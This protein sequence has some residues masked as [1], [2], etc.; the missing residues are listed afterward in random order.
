MAPDNTNNYC[1]CWNIEPEYTI[2]LNEQGPPGDN[3]LQGEE[4]FSPTITV[5]TNTSTEYKLAITNKDGSF[6]TPNLYGSKE[7]AEQDLSNVVQPMNIETVYPNPSDENDRLI[8]GLT[9][10]YLDINWTPNPSGSGGNWSASATARIQTKHQKYD[11]KQQIWFD[12]GTQTISLIPKYSPATEETLGLVKVDG[13][14]ITVT[15]DG[16]ISAVESGSSYVL[17]PATN[18]T[19]GG[20]K[21]GEG[22]SI[23]DDGTLSV[24]GGETGTTDYNDLTNKP[25]I[26]S[27]TLSGNVSPATLGFPTLAGDN[28]FSGYN[29]FAHLAM[30][31]IAPV[32]APYQSYI[33]FANQESFADGTA[34]YL[35]T[36]DYQSAIVLRS[37]Y[38]DVYIGR[39]TEGSTTGYTNYK[40]IDSGNI[41][42]YINQS[43]SIT[44]L[45]SQIEA[46]TARVAA[47]EA[48]INGG[49]A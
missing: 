46:L 28:N 36:A 44:E 33:T 15:E 1:D 10:G 23:T 41:N 20:I 48:N 19:L 27:I 14:T 43:T 29:N 5:N 13:S 3:G 7:W 32:F 2:T 30:N 18:D 16:T 6:I 24:T 45:I 40:V 34:I 17:P 49:N 35:G 26:N 9:I 21:V 42:N 12:V 37:R 11:P 22:L 31:N 4:G 39:Y 38:D 47:L 8:A 25:Q